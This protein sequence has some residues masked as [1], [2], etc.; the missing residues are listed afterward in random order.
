MNRI[1][2]NELMTLTST[3]GIKIYV[4][5]NHVVT[6]YHNNARDYTVVILSEGTQFN[7]KESVESIRQY[8]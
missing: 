7:V 3:N 4:N 1:N 5:I 2:L 8:F 6:F